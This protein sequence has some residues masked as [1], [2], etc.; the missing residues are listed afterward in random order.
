MARIEQELRDRFGAIPAQ[1]R[2][3]LWMVRLRLM[4]TAAGIGAITTEDTLLVL[5]LLPGRELD[6][7]G[8]TRRLPG[9][10]VLAHQV[11]LDRGVLGDNWREAL[12][13]AID[14]IGAVA[15]PV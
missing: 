15:V 1:A 13:R 8:L 10:N 4:A 11:R 3:L 9:S 6:R 2:N 14:A 5:R 7:A 12:V